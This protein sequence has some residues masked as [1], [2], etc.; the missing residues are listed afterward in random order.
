MILNLLRKVQMEIGKPWSIDRILRE[1]CVNGGYFSSLI[2]YG[3]LEMHSECT[4]KSHVLA[5]S[6]ILETVI[7]FVN[8]SK[9]GFVL[10]LK[11][12]IT[13]V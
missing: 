3:R 8:Q 4:L 13:T 10:D 11:F 2:V 5:A 1:L 9:Y 12:P 7:L 6:A